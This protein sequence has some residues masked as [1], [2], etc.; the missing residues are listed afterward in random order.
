MGQAKTSTLE[1]QNLARRLAGATPVAPIV[2]QRTTKA[3]ARTATPTSA[4][5]ISSSA[6]KYRCVREWTALSV[7]IIFGRGRSNQLA[8]LS[9]QAQELCKV[10]KPGKPRN[11]TYKAF[12]LHLESILG[13]RSNVFDSSGAQIYAQAGAPHLQWRVRRA[14]QSCCPQ[15]APQERWWSA[16][17]AADDPPSQF[18]C[19]QPPCPCPRS[20]L[21]KKS[22]SRNDNQSRCMLPQAYA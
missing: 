8:K 9:S 13:Q 21:H 10:K 12:T 1:G 2:A 20:C 5:M 4:A 3:S 7:T 15:A 16:Q 22:S 11:Q 18:P 19:Q 17:G 6:R 14:P